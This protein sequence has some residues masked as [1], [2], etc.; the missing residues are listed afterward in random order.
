MNLQFAPVPL[1]EALAVA[2][3][4]VARIL[5]DARIGDGQ[6]LL[7][8]L[9]AKRNELHL[10]NAAVEKLAN[11]CDGHCTKILGPSREKSPT[12]RTLDAILEVFALSIVLI[13]DPSKA[14]RVQPLWKVRDAS[15]VRRHQLSSVT[16]SRARPHILA[17]LARRASRPRWAGVN[18]R[19]F[20][21]ALMQEDGP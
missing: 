20:M 16:I 12:L 8:A 3:D 18:A 1:D 19:T 7:D 10:S 11:L 2:D 9:E 21:R 5:S 13:N 15:H 14:A 4:P 17:E 6:Q